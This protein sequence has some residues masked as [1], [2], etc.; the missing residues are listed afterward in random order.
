M[1]GNEASHP[2]E[3]GS[4]AHGYTAA[5]NDNT[6]EHTTARDGDQSLL[7][8]PFCGRSARLVSQKVEAALLW[9]VACSRLSACPCATVYGW[10]ENK[11]LVIQSWNTRTAPGGDDLYFG[12]ARPKRLAAVA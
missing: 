3:S 8:C 9:K 11:E 12:V 10:R 2:G 4:Q 7:A 5:L 6:K 1:A